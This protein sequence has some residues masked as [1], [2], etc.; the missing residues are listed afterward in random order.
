MQ[1]CR[2]IDYCYG[3][4]LL[5]FVV[6]PSKNGRLAAIFNFCYLWYVI[7]DCWPQRRYAF[8]WGLSSCKRSLLKPLG[9]HWSCM[10]LLAE[11]SSWWPLNIVKT[12]KAGC[13]EIKTVINST[14]DV[15]LVRFC[16]TL[17]VSIGLDQ[18]ICSRWGQIST[19][20]SHIH[21]F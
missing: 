6:G 21:L 4:S 20:M 14:H 7:G 2:I 15:F 11:C 1:H 5:N 16:F 8:L 9:H 13:Y 3:R 18:C 12:L 17:E 10:S 19:E